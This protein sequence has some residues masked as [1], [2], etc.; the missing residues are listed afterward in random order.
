M[1]SR[2]GGRR[3]RRGRGRGYTLVEVM[4][5]ILLVI[6]AGSM[7]MGAPRPVPEKQAGDAVRV[8]RAALEAA[9]ADSEAEGGDVEVRADAVRSGDPG[10]RFL[11]LAG[12]QGVTVGGVPGAEW[13]ELREGVVWRPGTADTDPA[14]VPTDGRIPGTVRCTAGECETGAA[15]YVVYYV[16]HSRAERVGWALVLH[17]TREVQLFRWEHAAGAWKSEGE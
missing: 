15:D 4:G 16:G 12:P 3:E 14:G 13:L 8:M 5:A 1:Q 9:L 7:F 10:G 2:K 17:R 6:L 11:A